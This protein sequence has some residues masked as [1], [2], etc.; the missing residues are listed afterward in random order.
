MQ[1]DVIFERSTWCVCWICHNIY[2]IYWLTVNQRSI[3]LNF[4][5]DYIFLRITYFPEFSFYQFD[6]HFC[7][8]DY[9]SLRSNLSRSRSTSISPSRSHSRSRS[10][11]RSPSRYLEKGTKKKL[12]YIDM[13]VEAIQMHHSRK[14]VFL[15]IFFGDDFV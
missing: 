8:D 10:R 14:H 9:R 15:F 11:S 1:M 13:V 3:P 12:T 2:H 4:F 5:I 7:M 6:Q